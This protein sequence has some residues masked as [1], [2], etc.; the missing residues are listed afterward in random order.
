M[1]EM[2]TPEEKQSDSNVFYRYIN[3]NGFHEYQGYAKKFYEALMD[4]HL[5][6]KQLAHY[7]IQTMGKTLKSREWKKIGFFPINKYAKMTDDTID[8][9]LTRKQIRRDLALIALSIRRDRAL[10]ELVDYRILDF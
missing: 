9:K 1:E 8:P 3:K 10:S 5:G 4:S 2:R 7:A 6:A